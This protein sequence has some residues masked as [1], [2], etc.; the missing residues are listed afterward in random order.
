VSALPPIEIG[1]H[2]GRAEAKRR[3]ASRIGDL[4]KHIPGG[5]AQVESSWPTEDRMALKVAAMGQTVD[6]L[7]DIED[8]LV[9]VHLVLP[10]LLSFM[11]GP[12]AAA[13][14][15]RGSDLLLPEPSPNRPS[16]P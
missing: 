9:R 10:P 11:A 13:I 6:A 7:L 4:P 15:N 1:H 3:I 2:L 5:M 14:R 8:S 16:P 12:I